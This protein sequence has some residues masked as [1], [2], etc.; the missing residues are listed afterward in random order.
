MIREY[1]NFVADIID[2]IDKAESFVKGMKFETFEKDAKTSFAVIRA[3]EIMGEA[4]GKIPSN[5][6]NKHKD[7]PW[8]EMAGMRH[9]L[10]HEYF[11]VKPRVVWKT[12][13]QDLPKIKPHLQAILMDIPKL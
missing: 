2:A 3:F 7:I 5:V 12:I 10:I 11:G 6:R 1:K 13:K 8:K 9:K 4:V